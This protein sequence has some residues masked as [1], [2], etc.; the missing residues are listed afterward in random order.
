MDVLYYSNF[1]KHSQKIIQ[2]LSRG[3]LL[4]SISAICIDKRCRDEKTNQVII[5]CE[6]GQRVLLPPNIQSVPALLLVNKNYQVVLGEE[7]IHHFEPAMRE[8]I[9]NANLGNGEPFGYSIQ[10]S[11]NTGGSNIV[12]EQ[13]TFYDMSPE[14]LSA[15]GNGTARQMYNYVPVNQD[16]NFIQTP[17]DTYKPDKIGESIT[18]DQLQQ[19]RSQEVPNQNQGPQYTYNTMDFNQ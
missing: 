13:F 12:S 18:I 7:I 2:F 4:E 15:K 8:K 1:C 16:L 14:E 3:G 6:N 9:S 10:S 11:A 17:P 5:I 19:Q